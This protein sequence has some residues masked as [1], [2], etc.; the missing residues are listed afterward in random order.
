M[1]RFWLSYDDAVHAVRLALDAG[2]GEIVVHKAPSF[3]VGDLPAA[4][5]AEMIVA[6]RRPGEKLHEC[7]VRDEERARCT[8][9]GTHFVL[10]PVAGE[11]MG[12]PEPYESDTNAEWIGVEDMRARVDDLI[13][14][15]DL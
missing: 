11:G 9:K 7:L 4:L 1:T 15:G 3:R 13:A 8:D 2:P 14:K 10:A 6:G 5:N 12:I